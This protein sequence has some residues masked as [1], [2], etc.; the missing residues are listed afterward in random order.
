MSMH[1]TT[2]ATES[3]AP[4]TCLRFNQD[5]IANSGNSV[6]SYI[7]N[8]KLLERVLFIGTQCSN[9]YTS[10]D[11]QPTAAWC[12]ISRTFDIVCACAG[13]TVFSSAHIRHVKFPLFPCS[14]LESSSASRPDPNCKSSKTLPVHHEYAP[15]SLHCRHEVHFSPSQGFEVLPAPDY[16]MSPCPKA[17]CTHSIFRTCHS[18]FHPGP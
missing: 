12:A 13:E 18:L 7:C 11:R 15:G 8:I 3:H 9:P 4:G 1:E 16:I 14:P 5:K 10:V 2:R 17:P 6:S